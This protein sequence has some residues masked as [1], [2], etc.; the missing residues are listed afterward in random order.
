[1]D[2][3]PKPKQQRANRSGAVDTGFDAW[4]ISK[5]EEAKF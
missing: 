1:M 4:F 5:K 2:L 3:T